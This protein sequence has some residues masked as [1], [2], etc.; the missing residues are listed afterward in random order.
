MIWRKNAALMADFL[1]MCMAPVTGM[2][3]KPEVSI[4]T[5]ESLKKGTTTT[6]ILSVNHLGTGPEHYVDRVALYDGDKLLKEW[7]YGRD[8]YVK[9]RSWDLKHQCSLDR[10]AD[11]RAVVH[12]SDNAESSYGMKVNVK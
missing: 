2:A 10:D 9:D 5:P 3:H 6:I 11:L 4:S 8:N 12:C 1:N 7:T